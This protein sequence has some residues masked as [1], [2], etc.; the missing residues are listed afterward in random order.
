VGESV[1]VQKPVYEMLQTYRAGLEQIRQGL[2]LGAHF[3]VIFFIVSH[4][5]L[6]PSPI[7]LVEPLIGDD[8]TIDWWR[9]GR[10]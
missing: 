4:M 9:G 6:L 1:S 5:N 8:W 10:R 7:R 3:F 2:C